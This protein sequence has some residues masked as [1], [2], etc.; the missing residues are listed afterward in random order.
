M[1]LSTGP[2]SA[3]SDSVQLSHKETLLWDI[4]NPKPVEILQEKPLQP[5]SLK[6]EICLGVFGGESSHTQY[7]S[8]VY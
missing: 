3:K 2:T 1:A 7:S 5:I 6:F 4:A 8:A